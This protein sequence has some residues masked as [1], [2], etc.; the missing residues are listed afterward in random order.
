MFTFGYNR[1]SHRNYGTTRPQCTS[2]LFLNPVKTN[3]LANVVNIVKAQPMLMIRATT[4][5]YCKF[6]CLVCSHSYQMEQY[7]M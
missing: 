1:S 5:N 6:C 3:E 2:T 4:Y 7:P